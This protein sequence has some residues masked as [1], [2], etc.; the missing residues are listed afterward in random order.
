[1]SYFSNPK[2]TG[3]K[4]APSSKWGPNQKYYDGRGKADGVGHG[5]YNPNNGFN[6]PA[7]TNFLGNK[8]LRDTKTYLWDRNHTPKW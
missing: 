3:A 2:N 6:R 5:H 8:A 7:V 1:M 4:H